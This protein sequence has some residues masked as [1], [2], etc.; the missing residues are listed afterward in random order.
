MG[1]LEV[2]PFG[3]LIFVVGSLLVANAWAIID[4]KLATNTAAR[5]AA[6]S[7]VEA[8][9]AATGAD[10]ATRAA[11]ET[12]ANYGRN[13]DRLGL[14]LEQDGRFARCTRVTFVASYEI[15]AISLPFGIG[16]GGPVEVRTRHSEIIDPLRS[17]LPAEGSCGY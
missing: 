8:T 16:F 14:E 1:G 17:G 12:I 9:S 2:L 7:Y 11:E 6:R 5:E 3:I 15:P 10:A 13:P 4:A